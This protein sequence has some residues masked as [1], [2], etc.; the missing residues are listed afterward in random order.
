M[1]MMLAMAFAVTTSH[2]EQETTS[3]PPLLLAKSYQQ[4]A[5]AG[6]LLSEKLDGVRAYWT[7]RDLISRN[8]QRFQPP[9]D[10]VAG[11]P[12]FALDGELFIARDTF[13]LLLSRI[14]TVGGDWQAVQYWVF[15]AP[16]AKGGLLQRLATVEPF[17]KTAKNLKIVP[18]TPIDNIETAKAI[19]AEIVAK[20]GEG[21]MLRDP[22]AAYVAGR[23]ETLL[24]LKPN[25]DAECR[26]V[27]H[28]FGKGKYAEKL[29]AVSCVGID[30]YAESNQS[31]NQTDSGYS[32]V[33]KTFRIG[34]GFSDIER[35]NPPAIGQVIR[36]RYR[37]VT[38]N[39]LPRF[40]TFERV[41]NSEKE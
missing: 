25:D 32:F 19:M 40:V 17:L 27:A 33:G 36:F 31:D 34:S 26:V 41:L 30:L 20:G 2:A 14:K 23:S 28:H 16:D 3:P 18:Q 21:V 11:F 15:D 6:F 12:P 24:K 13:S 4:Q 10:F 38:V 9:A 29:G 37:G 35:E 8:G 22:E 7:G 1:L 39:G 5:V